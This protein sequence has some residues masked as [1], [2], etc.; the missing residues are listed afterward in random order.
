[1]I[2]ASWSSN[3]EVVQKHKNL[4]EV[5]DWFQSNPKKLEI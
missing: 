5:K 1:M 2:L 4:D 3:L